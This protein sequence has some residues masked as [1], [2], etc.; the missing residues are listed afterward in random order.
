M[1]SG[2]NEQYICTLAPKTR[3]FFF[4]CNISYSFCKQIILNFTNNRS[5]LEKYPFLILLIPL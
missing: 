3:L 1:H 4:Y 5:V 2:A